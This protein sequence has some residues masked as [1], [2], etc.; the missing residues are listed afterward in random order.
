MYDV[1]R[2]LTF[3]HS[4]DSQ[5]KTEFVE[6]HQNGK[7]KD[8]NLSVEIGKNRKTLNLQLENSFIAD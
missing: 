3:V 5:R 6:I 2:I 4:R 8:V 1:E 7:M